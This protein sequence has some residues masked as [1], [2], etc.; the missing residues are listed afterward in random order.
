[1]SDNA[2]E[3]ISAL[4]GGNL[5]VARAVFE[6][7]IWEDESGDAEGKLSYEDV[8]T[9]LTVLTKEEIGREVMEEVSSP[10]SLGKSLRRL[11]DAGYVE[12]DDE[13][14]TLRPER[15]V[16]AVNRL[17]RRNLLW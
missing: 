11:S 3:R 16:D 4:S 10:R 13:R 15:I 8:Y 17:E 5:G 2:F 7:R 6:S 14:V 9:L 12:R 1:M